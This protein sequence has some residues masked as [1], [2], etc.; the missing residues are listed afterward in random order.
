MD[1]GKKI[2]ELREKRGLTMKRLSEL[3]SCTPSLISQ[4]EK[5]KTDP[6][7][8][9]LK[10]IADALN[11]NIVDFFSFESSENDVITRSDKRVVMQLPRWDA[12]IQSLIRAIG[13]KRM[14]AFYT[15][16][17]PGG[18]SHGLYSHDGEEFGIVLKGEMEL[19]LENKIYKVGE[20]DSFYFSSQIPHDWN[21]N[22]NQ[23][24]EVVWVITPPTF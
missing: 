24:V 7:I 21:N 22:G 1:I 23:D 11:V 10:K 5:G 9:T 12:R 2:K 19:M 14:Q 6:S 15:V 16:I 8:S 13:K 4:L 18:G 20:N 17:K 3:V